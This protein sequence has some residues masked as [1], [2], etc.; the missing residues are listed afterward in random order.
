[1]RSSSICGRLSFNHLWFWFGP[2]NL[3]LKFQKDLASGYWDI[4]LLIFWGCLPLEVIFIFSIFYLVWSPE[5]KFQIWERS[6]QWLLKYSTFKILRSSSIGGCLPFKLLIL[7]HS[8]S[9]KLQNWERSGQWLLRYS[10][11]N[12]LRSFSI[13]GRLPFE[14]FWFWFGPLSL[15]LRFEENLISGCWDIQLLIFWGPLPLKVVFVLSISNFG[16]VP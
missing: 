14:D 8:P 11:L 1:M 4:Q 15:S 5:L 7:V 13:G 6:D 2:L 12:I 9:I 16:F 3:S 10:C